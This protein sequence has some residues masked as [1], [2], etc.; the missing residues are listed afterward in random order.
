VLRHR[1]QGRTRVQMAAEILS[2]HRHGRAWVL[3]VRASGYYGATAPA[4]PRAK[5]SSCAS[6]QVKETR[7]DGQARPAPH[8]P[9]PA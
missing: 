3:I 1:P 2:A 5:Q 9:L 6:W 4:R 8:L 7:M